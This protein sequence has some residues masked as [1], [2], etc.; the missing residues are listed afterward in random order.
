MA[1]LGGG[2]AYLALGIFGLS[3]FTLRARTP[4]V[5]AANY[6]AATT[7]SLPEP[8]N[9]C[10]KQKGL[11]VNEQIAARQSIQEPARSSRI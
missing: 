2:A 3:N 9:R 6:Q 10:L 5:D 11:T 4:A 1:D 8:D 7:G